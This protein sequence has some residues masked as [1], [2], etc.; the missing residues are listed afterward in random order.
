MDVLRSHVAPVDAWRA[1]PPPFWIQQTFRR[2]IDA[3]NTGLFDSKEA[4][5]C[6]NALYRCWNMIG[7]KDTGDETLI[8]QAGEIEPV[9]EQYALSFFVFGQRPSWSARC[10]DSSDFSAGQR[11]GHATSTSANSAWL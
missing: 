3:F 7:V 2:W 1:F 10:S 6:S 5:F 11:R 9:Y 8:G 4:A